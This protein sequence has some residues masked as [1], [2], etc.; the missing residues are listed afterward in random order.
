MEYHLR[1]QA[2]TEPLHT[3]PSSATDCRHAVIHF[4]HCDPE[5]TQ[6]ESILCTQDNTTHLDKEPVLIQMD[7]QLQACCVAETLNPATE[8]TKPMTI[9]CAVQNAGHHSL[10]NAHL[11]S[12]R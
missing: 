3:R 9:C 5:N 12:F 10:Q 7:D 8:P 6:P 1:V 4:F 11:C 2:P